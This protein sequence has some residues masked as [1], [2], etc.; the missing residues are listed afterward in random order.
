MSCTL[1]SEGGPAGRTSTEVYAVVVFSSCQSPHLVLSLSSGALFFQ[2]PLFEHTHQPQRQDLFRGPLLQGRTRV[3]ITRWRTGVL[4]G[5]PDYVVGARSLAVALIAPAHGLGSP[6]LGDRWAGR[7]T[8]AA[9]PL[10][11]TTAGSPR[12]RGG[13]PAWRACLARPRTRSSSC[14]APAVPRCRR[15]RR[16]L[17]GGW[18]G[19]PPN[20]SLGGGGSPGSWRT[21]RRGSLV[22]A[23]A[24]AQP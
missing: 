22:D 3:D 12:R 21:S 1:P 19:E 5:S 9:S 6:S 8:A 7:L 23:R 17:G 24:G 2:P 10:S 13:R 14:L 4:V 20:G 18:S 15:G 11:V 16:C